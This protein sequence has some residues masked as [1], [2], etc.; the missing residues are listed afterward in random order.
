MSHS[1]LQV[2]AARCRIKYETLCSM[3]YSRLDVLKQLSPPSPREVQIVSK[4]VLS[5]GSKIVWPPCLP[6][7]ISW[8]YFFL[9]E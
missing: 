4:D 7:N 2:G 3:L 1:D 6:A 8:V 9:T 5:V